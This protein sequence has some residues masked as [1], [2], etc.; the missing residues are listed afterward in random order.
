M[1]NRGC[2]LGEPASEGDLKAFE[3][4]RTLLLHDE[5]CWLY[6]VCSGLEVPDLWLIRLWPLFEIKRLSEK[7]GEAGSS[8]F[9]IGDFM[10][11]S[12]EIA[13]DL[14]DPSRPV[15]LV[16]A[17]KPLAPNF[18]MFLVGIMTGKLLL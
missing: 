8:L 12:D 3:K 7:R 9:S 6:K 17:Q 10:L 13:A 4:S 16:G 1:S 14:A 2:L 11:D 18:S 5:F 15:V